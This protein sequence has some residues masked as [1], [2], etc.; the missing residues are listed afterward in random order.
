MERYRNVRSLFQHCRP[1]LSVHLRGGN[2]LLLGH[3]RRVC[4]VSCVRF[5]IFAFE[6]NFDCLRLQL[7]HLSSLLSFSFVLLSCIALVSTFY[8]ADD[9]GL[10]QLCY[11][12]AHCGRCCIMHLSLFW[13]R[14]LRR[15]GRDRAVSGWHKLRKLPC[16]ILQVG[17]WYGCVHGMQWRSV[18]QQHGGD[19]VGLLSDLSCQSSGK[20]S[21]DGLP[22][23]RPAVG[24]R[25][26]RRRLQY[27][28]L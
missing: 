2:L 18:Q 14:V 27:C 22:H 20:R 23:S 13:R 1:V 7:T 12:R 16:W 10:V 28:V 5:A 25:K 15:S 11:C 26:R 3:H 24:A 17:H 4:K 6:V 8:G 9:V 21:R 19:H